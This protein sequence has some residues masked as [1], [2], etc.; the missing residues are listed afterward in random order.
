[1]YNPR[2]LQRFSS[3]DVSHMPDQAS[4]KLNLMVDVLLS[5]WSYLYPVGC[6]F[7]TTDADFD[8]NTTWGG[9]WEDLGSGRW[10]RTA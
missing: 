1:M 5:M 3:Y 7:E 4:Y 10:H 9:K 6:Y 2:L 8:P